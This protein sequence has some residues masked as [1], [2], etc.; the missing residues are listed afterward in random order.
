[1][2]CRISRR[3]WIWPPF[4]PRRSHLRAQ[5]VF[6]DIFLMK[7]CYFS[8][9]LDKNVIH[10]LWF[11]IVEF[12]P[13]FLNNDLIII[14]RQR[15]DKIFHLKLKF[16]FLWST[17]FP[18]KLGSSKFDPLAKHD[19]STKWRF[20]KKLFHYIL[21]FAMETSKKVKQKVMNDIT[22]ETKHL[23]S[24]SYEVKSLKLLSVARISSGKF[25]KLP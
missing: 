6:L 2:L 5:E 11:F 19:K 4:W 24:H 14:I 9:A 12:Q 3:F 15:K 23:V 8:K 1:M 22:D 16:Q 18:S 25:F 20:V 17:F 10:A 21:D 13:S 7:R